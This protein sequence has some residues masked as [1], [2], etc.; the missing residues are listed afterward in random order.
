[1]LITFKGSILIFGS[2]QFDEQFYILKHNIF[3]VVK[4]LTHINDNS[5]RYI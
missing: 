4:L 2:T 5:K 3:K 1:M